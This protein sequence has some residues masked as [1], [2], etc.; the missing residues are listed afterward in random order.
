MS[1]IDGD[2]LMEDGGKVCS[3]ASHRLC[4][5]EDFTQASNEKVAGEKLGDGLYGCKRPSRLLCPEGVLSE[6][7]EG[8][9]DEKKLEVADDGHIVGDDVDVDD[10]YTIFGGVAGKY[11]RKRPSLSRR[12]LNDVDNEEHV[13]GNGV[14][15][16]SLPE[17]GDVDVD[18]EKL[19][20]G[21]Y[22]WASASPRLC[23]EEVVSETSNGYF[24]ETTLI[25]EDDGHIVGKGVE[26]R[27]LREAGE[28]GVDG[29]EDGGFCEK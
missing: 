4:P 21:L 8:Y 24:E 2:R 26:N 13:V 12:I 25:G 6:T 10:G 29:E 5:E 18:G 9:F 28:V 14:R 16:E 11:Y 1:I 22:G 3:D 15:R 20:V 19:G 27:S 23:P 17:G 7:C